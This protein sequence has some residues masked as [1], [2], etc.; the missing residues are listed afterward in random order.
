[1]A[2]TQHCVEIVMVCLRVRYIVYKAL[3]CVYVYA[4][5]C[6]KRYGVFTCSLHCVQ[7]VMVCLRVASFGK[8]GYGVFTCTLHCV[9]S[10]MVC[11]RVRYMVYKALWL[12]YV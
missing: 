12:V 3:W 4:T 9:K 10:V 8:K 5:L 2:W 11:L 1:M 6:T 7:S